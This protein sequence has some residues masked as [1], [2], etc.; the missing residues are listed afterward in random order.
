MAHIPI[1]EPFK[2]DLGPVQ[3]ICHLIA[4][5]EVRETG[6]EEP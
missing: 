1:K 5:N 6:Q 2:G 3:G 4:L